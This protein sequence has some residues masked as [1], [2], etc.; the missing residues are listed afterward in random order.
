MISEAGGVY[1]KTHL[2]GL[3][4]R[5]EDMS[6]SSGSGVERLTDQS[7]RHH[8]KPQDLRCREKFGSAQGLPH[9]YGEAS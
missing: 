5:C 8:E 1:L 6:T 2:L 7:G 4:V 3:C 9:A